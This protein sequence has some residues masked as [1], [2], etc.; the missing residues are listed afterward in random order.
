MEHALQSGC[1]F[2]NEQGAAHDLDTPLFLGAIQVPCVRLVDAPRGVVGRGGD[3]RYVGIPSREPLG[4]LAR[5]LAAACELWRVVDPV[6]Q[7]SHGPC[8]P[9]PVAALCVI[10]WSPARPQTYPVDA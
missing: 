5:V 10:R 4:Q 2:R 9:S 7:Y 8:L 3:H 6:E 1:A